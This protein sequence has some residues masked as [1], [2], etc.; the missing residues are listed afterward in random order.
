ML[1]A[2]LIMMLVATSSFALHFSGRAAATLKNGGRSTVTMAADLKMPTPLTQLE[3]LATGADPFGS[4]ASAAGV[5]S[6]R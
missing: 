2:V 1:G 5:G 6:P 3:Q 4:L